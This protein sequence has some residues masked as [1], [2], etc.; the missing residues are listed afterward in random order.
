MSIDG[1][2][3]TGEQFREKIG[4]YEKIFDAKKNEFKIHFHAQKN[5]DE[6]K[7]RLRILARADS[8]DKFVFVSG[9]K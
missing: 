9:I 3:I 1:I 8:E 2:A 4:H 6:V 7:K 5:F